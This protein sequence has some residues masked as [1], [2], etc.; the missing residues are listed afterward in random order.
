MDSPHVET[1]IPRHI[2][3]LVGCSFCRALTTFPEI[4]GLLATPAEF[5]RMTDIKPSLKDFTAEH[6]LQYEGRTLTFLRAADD[7]ENSGAPV[8]LQLVA[9]SASGPSGSAAPGHRE[10][11]SLLFRSV[12]GETFGRGLPKL[13][14]SAFD[15]SELFLSRIQ[16]PMGLPGGVYYEAIFN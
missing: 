4:I 13:V 5:C 8:E 14:D 3:F 16:P 11:F 12:K 2:G 1:P 10:A 15:P 6:F 7:P 9:V